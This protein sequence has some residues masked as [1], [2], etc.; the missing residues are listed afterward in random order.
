V[1]LFILHISVCWQGCESGSGL[2]GDYL[3]DPDPV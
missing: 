2:I 3:P 1:F